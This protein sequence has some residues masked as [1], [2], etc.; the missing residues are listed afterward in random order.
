MGIGIRQAIKIIRQITFC[1][2]LVVYRIPGIAAFALA[3]LILSV[4][5]RAVAP[6]D[7]GI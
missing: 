1:F 7:V 4:T 5:G 6:G 3:A 2:T